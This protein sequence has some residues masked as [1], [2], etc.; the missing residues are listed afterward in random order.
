MN[1]REVER[2]AREIQ[3]YVDEHSDLIGPAGQKHF[4]SVLILLDAV[5]PVLDPGEARP[6][7]CIECL[8]PCKLADLVKRS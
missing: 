4:A 5:A 8:C 6:C 3:R 2:L 7:S 1:R